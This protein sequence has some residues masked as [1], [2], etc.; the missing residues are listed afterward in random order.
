M[1]IISLP[2]QNM[3]A[4]KIFFFKYFLFR[5]YFPIFTEKCLM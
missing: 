2:I 4:I 5:N 3:Y 1:R